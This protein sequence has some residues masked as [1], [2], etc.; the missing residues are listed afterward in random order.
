MKELKKET[1]KKLEKLKKEVIHMDYDNIYCDL[2]N[3]LVDYD[4][5]AQDNLYLYD[6][7]NEIVEFVDDEMIEYLIKNCNNDIDRLRCFIGETYSSSIYKIDG[8]GN[9]EN[10]V[11]DDF[12]TCIDKIICKIKESEV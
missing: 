1:I 3:I 4:N 2:I 9:L 5:E 8:Y 11:D 7:L 6:T 10:V 12:I